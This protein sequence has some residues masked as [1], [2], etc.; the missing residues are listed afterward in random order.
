MPPLDLLA[1]TCVREE[2]ALG[3]SGSALGMH[4]RGVVA[5]LHRAVV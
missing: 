2:E 1:N 5:F 3:I 4:E